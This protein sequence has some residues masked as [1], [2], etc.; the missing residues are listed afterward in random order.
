MSRLSIARA[1]NGA[2]VTM[3]ADPRDCR[4]RSGVMGQS[5]GRP[6]VGPRRHRLS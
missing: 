1:L 4:Q 3:A 2:G 6:P 5:S